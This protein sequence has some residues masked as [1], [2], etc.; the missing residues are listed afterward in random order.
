[1]KEVLFFYRSNC[2]YC[3]QAEELL[4]KLLQEQPAFG[5]IPLRRVEE[6]QEKAL[7]DSYDY[8]YVP[9]F[10]VDG[11]KLLEGPATRESLLKVLEA[12]LKE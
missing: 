7:A 6:R 10:Y 12:A 1:M 11:K 5:A 2:P 4:E 9:C 3:R 8:W